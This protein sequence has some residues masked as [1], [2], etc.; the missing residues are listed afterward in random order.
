MS[1]TAIDGVYRVGVDIGGTFTDVVV[2]YEDRVV[3][4]KLLSTPDDYA[5]GV[6]AGT[7]AAIKRLGIDPTMRCEVVHATTVATNAIIERA[8]SRCALITTEGFRDV[9]EIGRLRIPVLY[10]INYEKPPPLV[11]RQD[12]FEVRERIDHNGN[13]VV[14]LDRALADAVAEKVGDGAFEAVAI[15]LLNAYAND[16]H[17]A[18]LADALRAHI[19]DVDVSISAEVLPQIGEYERTSTTVINAYV[20]PTVR[21]YLRSLVDGLRSHNVSGSILIMRSGGG[22]MSARRAENEPV[23]MVESGPAAGVLAASKLLAEAGFD[24]LLTFDIGGTTAKASIVEKGR[25]LTTIDYEVG[26]MV[27]STTR[28]TGG[29]GYPIQ[30][31]VIDIAEVGA[32]GG[33]IVWIDDGGSLRVGP[34]SAGAMPGPVC[35][36]QCGD[37]VTLTDANLLLGYINPERLAGDLAIRPDLAEQALR[38]RIAEPLG[39]SLVDAAYGIHLIAVSQMM[40]AV[41]AV[42]TQRGRDVRDYTLIA[43]G[44]NGP[45]HAVGLAREMGIATVVV[46]PAPGVFSATG[47]LVTELEH[48]ASRTLYQTL[49]DLEPEALADA[50]AK[51]R[52]QVLDVFVEEG[53]DAESVNFE[54][55]FRI[56]YAGQNSDLPIAVPYKAIDATTLADLAELFG[57]EHARTFGHRSDTEPVMF[58]QARVVGRTDPMP[59]EQR[60][61]LLQG[62]GASTARPA[63]GHIRAAY[64]GQEM[65]FCDCPVLNRDDLRGDPTSGPLLVEEYDSVT[66]VPP[67]CSARTDRWRNIVVEV[68]PDGA[69]GEA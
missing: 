49:A 4:E 55:S 30:I 8:G 58:V 19:P 23:H 39:L 45:L 68:A 54:M 51:L 48:E 33:S 13:V 41:R 62:L 38:D 56:R 27:S 22:V 46:P 40:G 35:Y 26:G 50:T 64:F 14:P 29:G 44:G 18:L 37:E 3:V 31:P 15:C 28:L 36:D 59:A 25:V 10:D 11:H 43:F 9:L 32:G 16:A 2:A 6:I 69:I 42:S 24:N 65:G 34:R 67:G 20:M 53:A 1:D 12:I 60:L 66:V 7:M 21:R 63:S 5:K 57:A 17:E 52:R 47:L 61:G